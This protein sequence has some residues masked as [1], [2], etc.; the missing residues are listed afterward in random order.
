MAPRA[1]CVR[2][3]TRDPD[4]EPSAPCRQRRASE[5][6]LVI[7][8]RSPAP[9]VATGRGV[10]LRGTA[11]SSAIGLLIGLRYYDPAT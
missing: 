6:G 4:T 9:L 11:T 3:R 1:A 5:A 7:Q 8:T 10:M 2:G